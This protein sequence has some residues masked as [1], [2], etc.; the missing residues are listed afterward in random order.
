MSK[1]LKI[2]KKLFNQN[3]NLVFFISLYLFFVCISFITSNYLIIW[4]ENQFSY[5]PRLNLQELFNSFNFNDSIFTSVENLPRGYHTG[6]IS[7]ILSFSI[8]FVKSY[9]CVNLV[10]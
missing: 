10:C 6:I 9:L 1:L 8:Y 2:S 5:N 4:G 3:Y 7:S